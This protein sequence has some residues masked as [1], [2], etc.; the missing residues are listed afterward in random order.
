MSEVIG[1]RHLPVLALINPAQNDT[2]LPNK[3]FPRL[4]VLLR[5]T[6]TRLHNQATAYP[7]RIPKAGQLNLPPNC[8]G[9]PI[10]QSWSNEKESGLHLLS[11]SCGVLCVI[12]HTMGIFD[13][14][15]RPT[16]DSSPGSRAGF[17]CKHVQEESKY[18][19]TITIGP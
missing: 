4:S 11:F 3:F 16:Q 19:F 18:E 5:N 10:L 12:C 8:S 14:L 17:L 1:R 2:V 13:W 6:Q 15:V 9:I 7:T